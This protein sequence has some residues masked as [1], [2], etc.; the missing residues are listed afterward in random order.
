M[1]TMRPRINLEMIGVP[2]GAVLTFAENE[3][4]TC[5]VCQQ[6]PAQVVYEGE[7]TSLS[8][9][10]RGQVNWSIPSRGRFTGN[11]KGKRFRSA[12]YDMRRTTLEE[13]DRNVGG[14]TFRVSP[15]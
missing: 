11:M 6:Y 7:T 2:L 9:S 5:V 12:E 14:T 8:D 4:I 1:T 3:E 15:V 13:T 10:A